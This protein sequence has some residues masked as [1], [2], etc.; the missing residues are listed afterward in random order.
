MNPH[1]Q[2]LKLT[3]PTKIYPKNRYKSSNKK[4]DTSNLIEGSEIYYIRLF[5]KSIIYDVEEEVY[6]IID[7]ILEDGNLKVQLLT[8]EVLDLIQINIKGYKT[9]GEFI[10]ANILFFVKPEHV[11]LYI[12]RELMKNLKN[13][14]V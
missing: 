2:L 11:Q 4:I 7:D 13:L 12:N 10:K 8:Q 3:Q 9:F 6:E 1:L 5:Q 14:K